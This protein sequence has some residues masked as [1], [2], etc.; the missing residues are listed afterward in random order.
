ML[1]RPPS[2]R[3]KIQEIRVDLSRIK[4]GTS[5]GRSSPR[6]G[7]L[8]GRDIVDLTPRSNTGEVQRLSQELQDTRAEVARTE[9]R[10][11][12]LNVDV[13]Q[14]H[15]EK[16]Q[17]LQQLQCMQQVVRDYDARL[18]V[19]EAGSRGGDSGYLRYRDHPSWF[20]PQ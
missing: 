8:A 4:S 18:Q 7:R 1:R 13:E 19:L 2:A 15:R 5:S 14:L 17:L 12:T 3:S 6:K 11:E 9:A 10:A 20:S 16:A